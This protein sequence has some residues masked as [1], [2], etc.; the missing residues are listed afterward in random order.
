LNVNGV[1]DGSHTEIHTACPLVHEQSAFEIE[2][3]IEKQKRDKSPGIDQIPLEL[4]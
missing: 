3:A 4:I 2:M 1:I